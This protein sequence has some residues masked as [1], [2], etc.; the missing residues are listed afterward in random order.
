M[1]LTNNVFINRQEYIQPN[2][3]KRKD[4]KTIKKGHMDGQLKV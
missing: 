1:V 3:Q 4:R 2:K